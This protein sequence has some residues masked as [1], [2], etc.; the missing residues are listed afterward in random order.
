MS[1]GIWSAA[2][3]ANAQLALLD[4]AA[5]NVANANTPG[6]KAQGLAFKQ[7][8]GTAGARGA[9]V[10]LV[11][12]PTSTT[13]TSVG[14]PRITGRPL[15]VALGGDGYFQVRVGDEDQY[16]R[17]GSF[18][19]TKDGALIDKSG[20]Q[21]VDRSGGAINIPKDAKSVEITSDGAVVADGNKVGTLSVVNFDKPGALLRDEGQRFKATAA[22]GEAAPIDPKLVT[23]AL[24]Q[25]NASPVRSMIDI[26]SASRG[27]EVCEKAVEAFR[28][29][30]MR[31]AQS[32]MKAA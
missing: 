2:S 30:D 5:N 31:A 9:D 25:S 1:D 7:L 16:T 22:S 29:A 32:I 3:G 11:D 24:E 19:V 28:D 17:A 14:A 26:V 12:A 20:A 4:T 10:R 13:D 23:G 21:V 27:F 15:D 6:Y 18:D 8:M